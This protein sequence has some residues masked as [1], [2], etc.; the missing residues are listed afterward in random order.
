MSSMMP[1]FQPRPPVR[2]LASKY[3]SG[4]V[5]AASESCSF[6]KWSALV[7]SM[8]TSAFGNCLLY[9]TSR[10]WAFLSWASPPRVWNVIFEAVWLVAGAAACGAAAWAAGLVGSAAAAGLVA[11]AAG[12]LVAAAAGAVVGA[13]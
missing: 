8:T 6:W 13:G 10:P 7:W 1:F 12:A 9:S 5:P 11:A 3:T 2:R 4:G